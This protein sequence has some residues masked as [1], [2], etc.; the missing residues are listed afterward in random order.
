M[1]GSGRLSVALA[2][3]GLD[4]E[5]PVFDLTSLVDVVEWSSGKELF[6]SRRNAS[7]LANKLRLT[8]RFRKEMYC[9]K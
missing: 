8:Q 3:Y 7:I 4:N 1:W 9:K 2:R 6:V 5:T